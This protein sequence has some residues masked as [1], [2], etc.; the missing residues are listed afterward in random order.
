MGKP[1]EH[2]W[3]AIVMTR[4]E[5]YL[6]ALVIIILGDAAF[7]VLGRWQESQHVAAKQNA[8]DVQEL[9][10]IL[11][12]AIVL[13]DKDSLARQATDAYMARVNKGLTDVASKFAKL[14]SVV[15]D[16]RGCADIA[17]AWGMRWNATADLPAGSAVSG[18]GDDPAGLHAASV[19][20]AR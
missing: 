12:D 18:G 4:L 6:V 2:A 11:S 20:A 13:R 19:P 7:Y 15:V 3:C 16:T 14:P 10:S 9:H 8:A 1:L 5:I 17:P